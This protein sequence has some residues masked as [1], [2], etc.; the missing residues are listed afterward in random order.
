VGA[1]SLP[2]STG[3]PVL[4]LLAEVETLERLVQARLRLL[5]HGFEPAVAES[6]PEGCRLYVVDDLLTG[7]RRVELRC[8]AA[9]HP[10]AERSPAVFALL[11]AQPDLADAYLAHRAAAR[12]THAADNA[13]YRAAKEAWLEHVLDEALAHWR[14]R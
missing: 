12:A 11:R 13:A 10:E 6:P 3:S 7:E 5:A 4:D 9:G 2:G 8:Y 14:R 1:T